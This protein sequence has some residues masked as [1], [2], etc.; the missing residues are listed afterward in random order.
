MVSESQEEGTKVN[1]IL[2]DMVLN[3]KLKNREMCYRF[4]DPF[5]TNEAGVTGFQ[6]GDINADV[7]EAEVLFN[8]GDVNITYEPVE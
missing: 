3:A 4:E 6:V 8:Y 7:A 5:P 2:G 1:I